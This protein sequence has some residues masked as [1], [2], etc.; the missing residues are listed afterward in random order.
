[1]EKFELIGKNKVLELL[2]KH[3]DYRVFIRRGYAYR[4]AKEVEDDKQ[5]KMAW[6]DRVWQMTTFEGRMNSFLNYYT[7]DVDIDHDKKEMHINGF[8]EN[9]LY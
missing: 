2:E 5:D 8:S 1:M 4:G 6:M 9:D 7:C 3:A